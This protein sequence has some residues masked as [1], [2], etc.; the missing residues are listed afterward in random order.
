M[1]IRSEDGKMILKREERLIHGMNTQKNL[2]EE[3]IMMKY[4]RKKAILM[5]I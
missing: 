4:C 1:I 5:I 3:K 2:M